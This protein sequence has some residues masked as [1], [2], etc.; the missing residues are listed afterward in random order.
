MQMP[1]SAPGPRTFA[2]Q[3]PRE[4]IGAFIQFT[5]GVAQRHADRPLQRIRQC[6]GSAFDQLHEPVT[7]Q[8]PC[9]SRIE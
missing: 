2:V 5:I 9:L 1:I 4:S 8:Q 3:V 7:V 6:V